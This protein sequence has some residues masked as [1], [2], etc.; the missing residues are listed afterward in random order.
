M[1]KDYTIREDPLGTRCKVSNKKTIYLILL[2]ICF[3]FN[4]ILSL[5]LY[6]RRRADLDPFASLQAFLFDTFKVL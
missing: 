2:N 6:W 4:D 3:L 1:E 5:E